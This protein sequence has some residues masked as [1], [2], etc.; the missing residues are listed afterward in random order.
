METNQILLLV[1]LIIP[2]ILVFLNRLRMDIAALAMAVLLGLLQFFGVGMLG[3]AGSPQEAVK[4]ISG[5]SQPVIITLISLFIISRGL[6][7][8]GVTRWIARQLIRVTGTNESRII[9]LF[10]AVTAFLSLFMNNLAAGALLAPSA[11][12]VARRTK[13]K[14]SKLLIP[15]A[16]GSL[17]G[18]VA[19]YFTTANIIMSD[20][21]T[22][23]NPPQE[24]LNILDFT[25]TGGLIAIAGIAFF[26]FFGKKL[27]PDRESYQNSFF[28]RHTGSE[29]EELYR[30]GERLWTARLFSGSPLIGKTISEA[31]IGHKYGVTIAAIKNGI[32]EFILPDAKYIIESNSVLFIVGREE[33]VMEMQQEGFSLRPIGQNG[34]LSP[35]GIHFAEVVLAPHSQFEGKTL[36]EIGFRQRF[37]LNA[38][39]LNRRERCYRTDVGSIPV[40]YGDSLLVIGSNA[41]IRALKQNADFIVIEPNLSDQPLDKRRAFLSI[42]ITLGTISASIA[43]IP[44]YLSVFFGAILS[45]ILRVIQL[46]EAYQSVEW[47]AI[48]LIAG[49]YAVS[50]SMVN[51]GMAELIGQGMLF[52]FEP[53]GGMG[54]AAGAFLL[55]SLLTQV[56]GGQVTALISGPIAIS[57]AISMGVNPQAVA[58]ATAIGCSASFLT[59]MAHPVNLIVIQPGGY[60]FQDFFRV[61]WLLTIICFFVLMVGMKIFWQL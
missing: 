58:V 54:I 42:L 37:N 26:F 35:Q 29:L 33:K 5:L 40:T 60:H 38:I 6:D 1:I 21:L 24:P 12:E 44:V 18:G 52:L 46:D 23:A 51:T 27:L 47:Q 20:L 55:T 7:K 50:Q 59:P 15:V 57:A 8:S 28:A 19:T 56:M 53:Y 3:T 34:F 14:P 22:I 11:L 49:M 13:I 36:K 9:A 45:I 39:A 43:G 30:I 10:T 61:G 4:A 2:L 32:D 25:P 31:G 41:L 16:Y 17:L 48:F